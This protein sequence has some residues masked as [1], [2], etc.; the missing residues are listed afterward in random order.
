MT[1][2][3]LSLSDLSGIAVPDLAILHLGGTESSSHLC[4][5][6]RKDGS[7][8]DMRI[9]ITP[10]TSQEGS[11][12]YWNAF[13]EDITKQ[14][15]YEESIRKV[16]SYLEN[17]INGAG[18]PIMVMDPGFCIV[19]VNR[20]CEVLI[21]R[22][23]HEVVGELVLSLF[24]QR[25]HERLM[26][27]LN[28]T[29]SGVRWESV[30][31][32]LLHRNG[33][34]R[35][36]VW[37]SSSIY[38]PGEGTP[39]ATIIQGQ[40]ITL[41]KKY[42][43]EKDQAVRQITKNFAQLSILNDG[44]RNPLNV[45]QVYAG[46]S[47]DARLSEII[48]GQIRS[49]D[50]MVTSLDQR[51]RESEKILQFLQKQYRVPLDF[52]EPSLSDEQDPS[53]FHLLLIE[54]MKAELFTILDS[55]DALVYVSDLDTYDLCYVNRFG[56]D[57]LGDVIGQKCYKTLQNSDEPCEF[58]T[59]HHITGEATPSPVYR[60]ERYNPQ[61]GRWY[62]CRDRT[63]TWSD[64][65]LVRLE[66]ATDITERKQYEEELRSNEGR[67]IDLI[68]HIPDPLIILGFDASVHYCNAA[69]FRLVG[70]DVDTT[71]SSLRIE[72]FMTPESLLQA[73]TDL[74]AIRDFC[75]PRR[76][77]Y[78]IVCCSG[79]IRR[80]EAIGRKISWLGED[81]DLVSLRDITERK[82]SEQA[83]RESEE[84]YRAISEFSHNAICTISKEGRIIWVNENLLQM[85]GYSRDTV[86]DAP[87]FL[88]FIAPESVSLVRDNFVRYISG[89][90]YTHH[91]SFYLLRSDGEKRLCEIYTVDFLDKS[92]NR[93]LIASLLDITDSTRARE[94]LIESENNF[95]SFFESVGEMIA[96][97]TVP[98]GTFL[99]TNS[100]LRETLGYTDEKLLDMKLGNLFSGYSSTVERVLSDQV[101]GDR[102]VTEFVQVLTDP[103][104]SIPAEM[105]VW[106]G[107]WNGRVCVYCIMK[108]IRE[109]IEAKERFELIFRK[110]PN[111]MAL[112]SV[113]DRVITDVNDAYL[114]RL[115]YSR[116]EVIGK[117]SRDLSLF[118]NPDQEE[119]IARLL[120]REG[121]ISNQELVVR[122]K[123]GSVLYGVF[124]GDLI[125]IRG[126][127]F[128]L[129]VMTDISDRVNTENLLHEQE[130]F[131]SVLIS[132]LPG[133]VYRCKNNPERTMLFVSDGCTSICGYLPDELI[134]DRVASY[135]SVVHPE[136]RCRLWEEWQKV[137]REH[138]VFEEVYQ[139]I[140]R[141][142]SARWVWERGQGV[143]DDEGDLV[144][145]EGFITD[146][147]SRKE[148]E[149]ALRESEER[150]RLLIE[151]QQDLVV[152]TDPERRV[153]Y[154]NP[155]YCSMIG[156][157]EEE[158]IGHAL[159]LP[160][161]PDDRQRIEESL[162][163]LFS[164]PHTCSFE[165]RIRTRNG[166]RWFSWTIRAVLDEQGSV[167][168]LV[169]TARDITG[170]KRAE[171]AL[172]ETNQKLNL[173]A[174]LTR[175]DII[176]QIQL[177]QVSH[178]YALASQDVST[179]KSAIES[180]YQAGERIESIIGFTREYQN[181]GIDSSDWIPVG[182][183]IDSAMY[184]VSCGD[185][186]VDNQ[187]D[188]DI[189]IYADPIIRKVFSTLIENAIRHGGSIT[190]IRFFTQK[191][192]NQLLLICEDDGTGIADE[193]KERIFE[194][195]FGN[196]TGLGLFFIREI[197]A[198]TS[199]TIHECG[200]PGEG[201]R[202]KILIPADAFRRNS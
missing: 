121:H 116:D 172:R 26:R 156:K 187:V 76:S 105:R 3:E 125:T 178:E 201:A 128:F 36:V 194:H 99:Y 142:G 9:S 85:T 69:T 57:I 115:G 67:L 62:D 34:V 50:E 106:Q 117:T 196:H 138:R 79:Q 169:G 27:L 189:E 144:C 19:R 101:P 192:G 164:P 73:I 143:F 35:S 28:T 49:I 181:F 148:M 46:M 24:P 58:C 152:K 80:V 153:L 14:N 92:G 119:K 167:T 22:S 185:V 200:E 127:P 193:F 123:D 53:G 139:V 72:P 155:A 136:Y 191:K 4:T 95:R 37:N 21:G 188:A 66:I 137:I 184:E 30:E 134:Q 38:E 183:A 195:G 174:G 81:C 145:I 52:D 40:D 6:C 87:S 154:A 31:I 161:H 162:S 173:L 109:E 18:V 51:W 23:S 165:E 197:L 146:I 25:E 131:E 141:S 107:T 168:A 198:I 149:E 111:L 151:N 77:E 39:V 147:T 102:S 32:D 175:H 84:R 55:I 158:L 41:Q 78:D 47:P 104:V 93:I 199:L 186:V 61:N 68:S 163:H 159:S 182:R 88:Q 120:S 74:Q 114:Q 122:S 89:Q 11:A 54:E 43:L 83:L 2:G 135:G 7:V 70:L 29:L 42:E 170:R 100:T 15:Q 118:L 110:N 56:R 13:I 130:R 157:S 75:G 71:P 96:V 86:C 108:D 113:P 171:A 180:A 179:I 44:I 48:D 150:F 126:R 160:T 94:A 59:N 10:G 133:F 132:S 17:L 190:R 64:G 82:E 8:I 166:W 140:T 63:I 202:F 20:A 91:Y 16:N 65:R 60:W 112:S 45:I 124:S 33:T 97:V 1:L 12:R 90:E 98:D 103:G 5:L 177:M 129:T 176:N